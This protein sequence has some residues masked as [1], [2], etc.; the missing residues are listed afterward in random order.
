MCVLG[1][2]VHDA[3]APLR[4]SIPL[5]CPYLLTIFHNPTYFKCVVPI[6][7]GMHMLMNFILLI[8][9]LMAGSGL[10][11]LNPMYRYIG[12]FVT[13]YNYTEVPIYRYELNHLRSAIT[14]IV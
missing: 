5:L 14:N 6:L 13:S 9:I 8:A 10:N 7:G 12:I 4:H 11:P 2:K 1:S 3:V